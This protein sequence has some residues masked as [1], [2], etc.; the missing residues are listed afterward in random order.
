MIC[1]DTAPLIWGVQCEP[2]PGSEHLVPRT[3][4]YL[5]VLRSE[6]KR[7]LIPT[8]VIQEYLT[9]FE[10]GQMD[11]QLSTIE[12]SF[13]VHPLDACAARLTAEIVK[14]KIDQARELSGQPRQQTLLDAQIVAIAITS[15]AECIV[16]HDKHMNVLADGKIA[17]IEVPFIPEEDSLFDQTEE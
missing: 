10:V 3:K 8:P 11:A 14:K 12:R 13:I 17:V 5:D 15:G 9:G 2:H 1:F 6:K 7:I 16:S 4:K